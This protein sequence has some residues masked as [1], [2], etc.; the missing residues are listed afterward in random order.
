MTAT[1]AE[2]LRELRAIAAEDRT[3]I[4]CSAAPWWRCPRRPV[5]DRLVLGG[6]AVQHIDSGGR[7]TQHELSDFAVARGDQ[8]I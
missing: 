7:T 6:D 2:G 1:F 3:A 5:A 4:M 8:L